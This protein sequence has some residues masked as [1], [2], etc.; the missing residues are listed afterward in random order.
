MSP[1]RRMSPSTTS[2]PPSGATMTIDLEGT[3]GAK[4]AGGPA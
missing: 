1:H 3:H 2:T 4:E